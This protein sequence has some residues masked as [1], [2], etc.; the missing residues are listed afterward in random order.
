MFLSE[1]PESDQHKRKPGLRSGASPSCLHSCPHETFQTREG[2]PGDAGVDERPPEAHTPSARSHSSRGDTEVLAFVLTAQR[3][4]HWGSHG[5]TQVTPTPPRVLPPPLCHWRAQVMTRCD[6]PRYSLCRGGGDAV[7]AHQGHYSVCFPGEDDLS[8]RTR[9]GLCDLEPS[10]QTGSL[11]GLGAAALCIVDP[12]SPAA[13]G[14]G[15]GS[16][17]FR[18]DR[19]QCLPGLGGGGSDRAVFSGGHR[20]GQP[21]ARGPSGI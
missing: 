9:P 18:K 2:P 19:A 20:S 17:F 15:A 6:A 21:G 10:P 12:E 1:S 7:P 3:L 8:T 5:D 14:P 4:P 11:P 16:P 13:G